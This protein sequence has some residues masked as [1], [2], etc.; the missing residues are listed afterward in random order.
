MSAC[1]VVLKGIGNQ[2]Y[3][4]D[5]TG[6][7]VA[8]NGRLGRGDKDSEERRQLKSIGNLEIVERRVFELSLLISGS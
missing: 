4:P 8:D 6:F 7:M 3:E 2:V 5:T 1:I